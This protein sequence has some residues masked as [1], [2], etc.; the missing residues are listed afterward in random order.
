MGDDIFE[1]QRISSLE[2]FPF[3]FKEKYEQKKLG[4]VNLFL[5]F[6][7]YILRENAIIPFCMNGIS[8]TT[9]ELH[10]NVSLRIPLGHL[11]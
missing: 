10:C 11:L 1:K 7:R 9:L 8:L 5:R 6:Q 3:F 4:N 2:H